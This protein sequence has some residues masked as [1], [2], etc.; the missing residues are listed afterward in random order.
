MLTV[1]ANTS[2]FRNFA[3]DALI[4]VLI[5]D[6]LEHLLAREAGRHEADHV[7]GLDDTL[8]D[9]TAD[10]LPHTLDVVDVGDGDAEGLVREALGGLGLKSWCQRL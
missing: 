7:T 5:L 8:L 9:G 4:I 1:A 2:T 6:D 3:L 10:D